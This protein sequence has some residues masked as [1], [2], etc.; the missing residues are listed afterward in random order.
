MELWCQDEHEM[1][2]NSRIDQ[3]VSSRDQSS[4]TTINYNEKNNSFSFSTL[5]P[6]AKRVLVV[7]LQGSIDLSTCQHQISA[8]ACFLSEYQIVSDL[9]ISHFFYFWL[10][11]REIS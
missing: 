11:I 5:I 10:V 9:I 8:I 6:Y 4:H 2:I 7:T 3:L 1:Y